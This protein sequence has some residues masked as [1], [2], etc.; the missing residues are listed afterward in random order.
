MNRFFKIKTHPFD[1][2]T[3]YLKKNCEYVTGAKN[4][5]IYDLNTGKVFAINEEG[6]II[7]DGAFKTGIVDTP[8]AADYVQALLEAD[9]MTYDEQFSE[10]LPEPSPVLTYVW[11]ELTEACNLRCIHCYGQWG[12]PEKAARRTVSQWKQTLDAV[13][14]YGCRG[15]QLIGGEP[16]AHHDFLEILAYAKA[17]GMKTID[18]FSNGTLINEEIIK[19]L[20]QA[21]ASVRVSIYGYNPETHDKITNVPGS[22]EKSIAALK[23]LKEADIPTTIAVILMR[24]NQTIFPEIKQFI[25]SLGFPCDK[26]DTIRKTCGGSQQCHQITDVEVLKGRYLTEA[27]FDTSVKTFQYNKHWNSCW[28]GKIAITAKGEVIPCIFARESVLGNIDTDPADTIRDNV[29]KAWGI[30]KD[31]V[32]ICKDCEYRY[33][34]HDCRP[35]A[36][37]L[38]E[39][40]L[41]KYPRCCYD[42]I[43]GIWRPIE[44]VTL[45]LGHE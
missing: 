38:L 25:E 19:H 34:C 7:L 21:Q 28:F 39:D 14:N 37:G 15:V 36:A 18:V 30:T 1:P 3:I 20:K 2:K 41:G 13:F 33:S 31:D 22:F 24:E 35:L 43:E 42:P 32:K 5:A 17:I 8:F 40:P 10:P 26:Y 27:D 44:D 9:V 45:E 23:L 29:L 12:Y 6:R 4:A 11:L 16:L